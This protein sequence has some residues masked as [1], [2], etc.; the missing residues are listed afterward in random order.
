MTEPIYPMDTVEQAINAIKLAGANHAAG[1]LSAEEFAQRVYAAKQRLIELQAQPEQIA[2]HLQQQF[3]AAVARSA[4]V[5][6]LGPSIVSTE[7]PAGES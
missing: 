7:P 6:E 1:K 5:R 4:E 2:Q 3:D